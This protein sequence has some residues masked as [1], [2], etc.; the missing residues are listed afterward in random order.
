MKAARAASLALARRR[1]RREA[2]QEDDVFP[3]R[4]DEVPREIER[5]AK[6]LHRSEAPDR[7]PGLG[8][9]GRQL[10]V[11]SGECQQ[12]GDRR[13]VDVDEIQ[14]HGSGKVGTPNAQ[15]S[16]QRRLTIDQYQGPIPVGQPLAGLV[17][18][19]QQRR[20]HPKRVLAADD[21]RHRGAR[22][23]AQDHQHPAQASLRAAAHGED[24]A[25]QHNQRPDKPSTTQ[26]RDRARTP[27]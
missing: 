7:R 2:R 22:Y 9:A 18:R 23:P 12:R 19:G 27:A 25:D 21:N 14:G 8:D 20:A 15:L 1:R 10:A 6:V 16:R 4:L 26:A 5:E 3:E 13:V 24:P 11:Y 17:G